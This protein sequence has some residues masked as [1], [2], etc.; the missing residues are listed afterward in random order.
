MRFLTP[1]RGLA[2]AL[3]ASLA[4]A[5]AV[6]KDPAAVAAQAP[7]DKSEA[8]GIVFERQQIMLQLEKDSEALGEMAAGLRKPDQLVATTRSIAQGA[9]D[10]LAAFEPNVPGGRAKPEVWANW[11]DFRQR[12]ETFA[13]RTEKMAKIAE[14]GNLNGVVEVMADALPCRECHQVYRAPKKPAAAS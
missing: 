10:S 7:S 12:L 8:E 1:A 2:F 4:M 3:T 9:K 13:A 14:S 5:S 6:A 11:P